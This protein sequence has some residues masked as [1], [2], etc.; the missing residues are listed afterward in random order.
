LSVR[1]FL[2]GGVAARAGGWNYGF[3]DGEE[4]RIMV[5][6]RAEN[7]VME[8]A[9]ARGD[10]AGRAR[11]GLESGRLVPG[12]ARFLLSLQSSAGN[13]AV[14]GMVQRRR[15]DGGDAGPVRDGISIVQRSL[16]AGERSSGVESGRER[17]GPGKDARRD[18]GLP[19]GLRAGIESLSGVSLERVKVHY[20]SAKPAQL[21]AV[22]FAQGSDIHVGPRQERHL[23]HEAWH[24]V[25]QAQGRVRPTAQ[26]ADV[27][28]NYSPEL[29]SEADSM[30]ARAASGAVGGLTAGWS[31]GSS[32]GLPVQLKV[33]PGRLNVIGEFHNDYPREDD[34]RK[35]E[36]RFLSG[37]YGFPLTSYW[38]EHKFKGVEKTAEGRPKGA[39]PVIGHVRIQL[40]ALI[41][42]LKDEAGHINSGFGGLNDRVVV[43]IKRYWRSVFIGFLDFFDPKMSPEGQAHQD[44]ELAVDDADKA[45]LKQNYPSFAEAN[46]AITELT[47]L[48]ETE[49]GL[50]FKALEATKS[51]VPDFFGSYLAAPKKANQKEQGQS[52]GKVSGLLHKIDQIMG[53]CVYELDQIAVVEKNVDV[54]REVSMAASA[55][56]AVDAGITG[57]W[58][59]GD[60]H[61]RSM[62][63]E[64]GPHK[65][66]K[67]AKFTVTTRDEFKADKEAVGIRFEVGYRTK[68][69]EDVY[70]VGNC[71]GLG[72][73]D[74]NWAS[75]LS[76]KS[77]DS[78]AG[79]VRLDKSLAGKSIEY[80]YLVKT[81]SSVRWE[82]GGH[83]RRSA[84]AAGST[85]DFSDTWHEQHMGQ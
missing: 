37:R 20:D 80:K 24:V 16:V 44:E 74:P 10:G 7:E 29:E 5:R 30:G 75:P 46:E 38:T 31:L 17:S 50:V 84:P 70:V 72:N 76:F 71:T 41:R 62:T 34:D 68:P 83:H 11:S 19:D 48:K 65:G 53:N 43:G 40:M 32:L 15:E 23:P 85:S 64:A 59:V 47:D 28:V 12:R 55:N 42:T 58:K 54:S 77:P 4:R 51:I 57:T 6:E 14:A 78:W 25:Q 33:M 35:E 52:A 2:Y 22:A 21:D 82:E 73:W 61:I 69:G 8:P 27:S 67:D 79:I 26:M 3:G 56:R 60:S 13:R 18:T 49:G 39:D 81:G 63:D 45:R 66:I 1:A 9:R 36:A